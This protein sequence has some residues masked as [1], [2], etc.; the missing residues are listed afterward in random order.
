MTASPHGPQIG[1]GEVRGERSHT[2]VTG[3][4]LCHPGRLERHIG[5]GV[6]A[7]VTWIRVVRWLLGEKL[8]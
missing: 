1:P 7:S 6:V 2:T 8:P 3:A 5:V 4:S